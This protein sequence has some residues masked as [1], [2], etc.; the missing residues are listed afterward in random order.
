MPMRMSP[1]RRARSGAPP[2]D[3][4]LPVAP[5]P[6]ARCLRWLLSSPPKLLLL[7]A[8]TYSKGP[9]PP[10]PHCPP[11]LELSPAKVRA[12]SRLGLSCGPRVL[13][14][15]SHPIQFS[16]PFQRGQSAHH[17]PPCFTSSPSNRGNGSHFC[18]IKMFCISRPDVPRAQKQPLR[19]TA[20]PS[21]AFSIMTVTL[22][23]RWHGGFGGLPRKLS[24]G[25][26]MGPGN[27][28]TPPLVPGR[29]PPASVPP[30]T[31]S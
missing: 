13:W 6:D 27:S 24:L 3:P 4:R 20:R 12:V 15:V 28:P 29:D 2:C 14:Q 17:L 21:L 11:S 26:P 9:T 10:T 1:R 16:R 31:Y 7:C 23:S 5:S 30:S 25:G 8:G 19:L 18:E 22:Q